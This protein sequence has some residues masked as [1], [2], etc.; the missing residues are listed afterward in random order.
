MSKNKN[1]NNQKEYDV[2]TKLKVSPVDRSA[3]KQYLTSLSLGENVYLLVLIVKYTD[4]II[5]TVANQ[6]LSKYF[7]S[8]VPSQFKYWSQC[9]GEFSKEDAT[10]FITALNEQDKKNGP[11]DHNKFLKD[12]TIDKFFTRGGILED[13]FTRA[14]L[15]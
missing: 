1:K 14:G 9:S 7:K 8:N 10:L 6:L 2:L 15:L 12:Y 3:F 5:T 4:Y 11:N 13:K